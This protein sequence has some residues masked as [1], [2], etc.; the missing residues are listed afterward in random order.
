MKT[1]EKNNVCATMNVLK[2]RHIQW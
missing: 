2:F 1:E